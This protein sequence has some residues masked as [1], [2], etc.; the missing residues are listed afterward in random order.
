LHK[1]GSVRPCRG[2]V[3]HSGSVAVP[4]L[5]IRS[6]APTHHPTTC[7]QAACVSVS[8]CDLNEGCACIHETVLDNGIGRSCPSVG[9]AAVAKLANA[10][11][12]PAHDGSVCC[13]AT[14]VLTTSCDLNERCSRVHK[15]FHVRQCCVCETYSGGAVI[16]EL[17]KIVTSPAHHRSVRCQPTSVLLPSHNLNKRCSSVDESCHARQCCVCETYSGVVAIAELTIR[18]VSPAHH[19]SVVCQAT[20]VV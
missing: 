5:T 11:I 14:G 3:P 10:A 16:A 13:Q 12:A 4:E 18:V 9:N 17:T 1:P 7:C 19:R 6:L 15:P 8:G 20:S 2:C